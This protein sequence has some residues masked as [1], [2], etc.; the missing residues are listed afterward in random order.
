MQS[1]VSYTTR[2]KRIGEV[3]GIDYHFITEDDFFNKQK[4]NFFAEVKSYE[5]FTETEK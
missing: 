1:V 3:D 5:V 2:P 4:E